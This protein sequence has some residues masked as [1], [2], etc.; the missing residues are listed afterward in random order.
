MA[1]KSLRAEDY[2]HRKQQISGWDAGVTSY[3]IGGEYFC[4]VDNASPGGRIARGKGTTREAAEQEAIAEAGKLLA[5][6][7]INTPS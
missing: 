1:E 2:R 6:T 4:E 7:R 5:A 3:K